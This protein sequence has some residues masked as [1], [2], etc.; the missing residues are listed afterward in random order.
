MTVNPTIENRRQAYLE[1][2]YQR[3]NR[4]NQVYT[5]LLDER[6]QQLIARDVDEALGPLGDWA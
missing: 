1:W 4:T 2:L 3:S 5:G 6:I